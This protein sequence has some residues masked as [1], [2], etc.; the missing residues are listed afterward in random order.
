MGRVYIR[1]LKRVLWREEW[2][3]SRTRRGPVANRRQRRDSSSTNSTTASSHP[4][5]HTTTIPTPISSTHTIHST[6]CPWRRLTVGPWRGT[7]HR[8]QWSTA[9]NTLK[10]WASPSVPACTMAR[11]K[12]EMQELGQGLRPQCPAVVERAQHLGL[13]GVEGAPRFDIWGPVA[14]VAALKRE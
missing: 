7:R 5:P 12:M 10:V 11:C 13:W 8:L 6:H 2:Y 4:S 9:R 14:V 3:L 1:V